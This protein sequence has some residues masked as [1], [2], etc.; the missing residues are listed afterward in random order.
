ME[1]GTSRSMELSAVKVTPP[2]GMWRVAKPGWLQCVYINSPTEKGCECE[3]EDCAKGGFPLEVSVCVT[4]DEPKEDV[5]RDRVAFSALTVC[6]PLEH[7]GTVVLTRH[8]VVGGIP[9]EH[10][11]TVALTKRN[12]VRYIPLYT[13]GT[14]VPARRNVSKTQLSG[15]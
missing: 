1:A 14:L 12:V 5:P 7:G 10:G 6:I 13:G 8:N 9:L 2:R 4:G 3:R 15:Q 11:G